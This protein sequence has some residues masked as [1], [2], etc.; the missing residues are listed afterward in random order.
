MV[1]I[2]I[3]ILSGTKALSTW[4]YARD[5]DHLYTLKRVVRMTQPL[6]TNGYFNRQTL[7]LTTTPTHLPLVVLHLEMKSLHTTL[8]F[9]ALPY[10]LGSHGADTQQHVLTTEEL[11]HLVPLDDIPAMGFGTWN[12]EKTDAQ[13]AVSAAIEA[14]YRHIDCAATYGNEKEVGAGI[15]AGSEK[16]GINRHEYWVTSKLWNDAY[17]Y[18]SNRPRLTGVARDL[19]LIQFPRIDTTRSRFPKRS[20]RL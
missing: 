13:N 7:V 9:C 1:N 8:F 16:A 4:N 12:I 11:A 10:V 5:E 18:S 3:V 15:A 20:T 14:G 17:V 19:L 2:N 6:H